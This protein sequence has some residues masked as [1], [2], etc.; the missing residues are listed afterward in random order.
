MRA[1]PG[2]LLL[3]VV[4]LP[5]QAQTDN[6]LFVRPWVEL[7]PLVRIDERQYPIPVE[8]AERAV[9]EEARILLSGMVFGWSFDYT[10]PNSE[11]GVAERFTLT[12]IAQIPW[13]SPR[14][15]VLETQV[16]KEKLWARVV[17]SMDDAETARRASWESGTALLSQGV[18]KADVMK[19][20]DTKVLSFQDSVRDAIRV[21]LHDRYVDAPREVVGDVVLWDDPQTV[22]RSGMLRTASEV[23]IMVRDVIPYRIF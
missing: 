6:R 18:G 19:G 23:K 16:A 8:K 9:L 15:R 2:W 14:L 20:P 7:E 17:Y 3:L 22:V 4:A 5:V 1:N 10:P 21:A 11:R 13:G 12:P